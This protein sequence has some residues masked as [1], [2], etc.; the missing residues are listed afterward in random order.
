MKYRFLVALLLLQ[1]AFSPL[2]ASSVSTPL[3]APSPSP[4]FLPEVTSY[5]DIVKLAAPGVVSISAIQA[6]NP[7]NLLLS[8]DMFFDFFFGKG[9]RSQGGQHQP[10]RAKSL[11]S[12]VIVDPTGIVVTCVHVIENAPKIIVGL[13]DNREF[14]GE[15][16]AKDI[17]ND[18][19]A[20]R[21]KKVPA[22]VALPTVLMEQEE[23]AIGDVTL[24]IGNPF[25]V[26]QTVTRGIISALARNVQGRILIQTDAPIN[27]GNSGGALISIRGRLVGIPN[28]ILSKTGA[29]LG[30]GFAIPNAL[31]Q[32]LLASV[33]NGGIIM[34]PWAGIQVQRLTSEAANALG[35]AVPQG[36]LVSTLHPLSPARAAGLQ[37]GDVV[38]AIN[39]QTITNSDDFI[40]RLQ[41]IPQGQDIVL[42]I[43]RNNQNLTVTFKPI[44]PPATPA[45]DPQRITGFGLLN[46]IEV[47]NLSPALHSQYQLPPALPE[48]GVV[49]TD[50]GK[51]SIALQLRLGR[52]DI[53][54]KVNQQKI[55]SVQHLFQ[56]LQNFTGT[57]SIIIRQRERRIEINKN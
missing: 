14:E 55:A 8:N 41:A 28:A 38:L 3:P 15:V 5:A 2:Y 17:Q 10:D 50:T 53:I 26:G 23:I 39:L 40:Y 30:I 6:D 11:G 48:K 4:A 56:V 54:E 51:N 57:G 44:D 27:P 43:Y 19:A 18:L 52:G 9:E 25:G 7:S 32:A 20:I 29:N 37:A 13:S 42:L 34:R 22:N 12:G 47:A 45:P 49:I 46:D 16:I 35:L 31:I 21:L 24:A 36:V 1:E 33:N